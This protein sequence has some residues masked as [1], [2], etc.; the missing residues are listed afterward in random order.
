[1]SIIEKDYEIEAYFHNAGKPRDIEGRHIYLCSPE[2]RAAYARRFIQRGV[3]LVGGCCGTTPEHI[4][5]IRQA[6]NVQG[7][8]ASR[9][10]VA[11][12]PLFTSPTR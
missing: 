6:V 7:V 1:M 9:P 11:S 8:S 5:Q 12:G 4:R 10:A 2:Y 3:R